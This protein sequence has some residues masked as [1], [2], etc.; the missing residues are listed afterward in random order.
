M[1][2]EIPIFYTVVENGQRSFKCPS[3]NKKNVHSSEEGHR[4]PHC[5]CW[6]KGYEIK[7]QNG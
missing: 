7:D 3:C 1:T 6:P 5:S 2:N 4:S